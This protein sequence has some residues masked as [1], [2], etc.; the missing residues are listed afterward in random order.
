[1]VTL[2]RLRDE[3]YGV[4]GITETEASTLADLLVRDGWISAEKYEENEADEPID[5]L[6]TIPAP[7]F[8]PEWSRY[9]IV[10]NPSNVAPIGYSFPSGSMTA[11]KDQ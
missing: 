2:G 1:M 5:A 10:N 7:P 6:K 11:V 9:G 8:S 3:I 4:G